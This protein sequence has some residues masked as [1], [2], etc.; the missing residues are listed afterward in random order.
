MRSHRLYLGWQKLARAVEAQAWRWL[1]I[2]VIILLVLSL[3]ANCSGASSRLKGSVFTLSS[4]GERLYIPGAHVTLECFENP[5]NSRSADTDESGAFDFRDLVSGECTA[6]VA[7][8]GFAVVGKSV[9]LKEGQ[10]TTVEF[11]LRL[12][13]AKQDVNVTAQVPTI[14]VTQTAPQ[15]E[16]ASKALNHV[17]L[18]Q[19]QVADAIPLVPGA[20]RGPDGLLNIKGARANQSGMLVNSANAADPVTG[21]QGIRLPIDV[22]ESVQVVA[23]PYAAEYGK[24][25]GAVTRIQTLQGSDKYKVGVQNLFPRLRKR[26]GDIRG[27]EAATPRLTVSGPIARSKAYFVQSFEYRYVRTRVPGLKHLDSVLQSDTEMES[28]DSHSQ[29]DWDITSSQRISA[30]LSIFPQKLRYANLNTF[31]P[32]TVT[33][34]YHGRGYLAAFSHRWILLSQ[35]FLQSEFSLEDQDA[36]IL[37][38]TPGGMLFTFTPSQN[39]GNYFNQQSRDSRRYQWQE[40]LNVHP[41]RGLGAHLLKIGTDV[42]HINFHG[43]SINHDV[44]VRT[45]AGLLAELVQFQGSGRLKESGSEFSFFAQDTWTPNPRVTIAPGL[46]IDNDTLGEKWNLAPRIGF[47][48]A[49]TKDNRTLLRGGAGL[50]YDKIPLNIH[51]FEQFQNRIITRFAPDGTVLIPAILFNNVLGISEFENPRSWAW[52]AELDREVRT[53]LLLR[54]SYQ[55]RQ[56]SR[57]YLVDTSFGQ[58][59]AILLRNTGDSL[60]RE[61]GLT[62]KY[63]FGKEHSQFVA[64]YTRSRSVGDLNY[65]NEYFGNFQNPLIRPN[66]RSLQNFDVPNRVLLWGDLNFPKDVIVS[67]VIDWRDG[68]PYSVLDSYFDFV[69]TR[70]RAGRFPRFLSV[71]LQATKGFTIPFKGRKYKARAGV[72]L[73]NLTNHFNPRD[74]YNNLSGSPVASRDECSAFGE[75]CNSVGRIVRGKLSLEF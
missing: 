65:F 58:A 64:S 70:N 22:V 62:A 49:L 52:N 61:F 41:L 45:D 2:A 23:N 19:E 20:V 38:S 75:F 67:P 16:I 29:V 30:S 27:I 53:G 32:Q 56:S 31:N 7:T 10:Q 57:E 55:Q 71:D 66:Q 17:P 54:L 50:F 34:N 25:A 6:T 47:S 39:G 5:A 43:F 48:V 46:R 8:P 21:E 11:Q 4:S 36:D 60:Y 63:Q 9:E 51:A 68:F 74:V 37:P 1:P 44:E 72:R 14:D 12:A 33:P 13:S 69:G 28:F 26:N 15:A 59:P 35:S 40:T 3:P 73:F 18:A 24:V 42:T